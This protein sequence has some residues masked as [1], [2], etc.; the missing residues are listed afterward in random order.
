M[1]LTDDEIHAR[2]VRG[3]LINRLM[4]ILRGQFPKSEVFYID[5]SD[6]LYGSPSSGGGRGQIAIS[7]VE[8]STGEA[9]P[10]GRVTLRLENT[11]DVRF[12]A[13]FLEQSTRL[14][15][16]AMRNDK[17]IIED[18]R[19]HSI[20]I[21]PDF[22]IEPR[23][24][25]ELRGRSSQNRQTPAPDADEQ[26]MLATLK[27]GKE[28]RSR[29]PLPTGNTASQDFWNLEQPRGRVRTSDGLSFTTEDTISD[30]AW[31]LTDRALKK[32]KKSPD[33]EA[34][35]WTAALD[36]AHQA[37]EAHKHKPQRRQF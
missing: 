8:A 2:E 37:Y 30:Q 25:Q 3:S 33:T 26:A 16:A 36:E 1:H 18:H 14:L 11:D 29:S 6:S 35:I 31:Q 4:D 24:Q 19:N 21:T 34:D 9:N 22:I 23:L 20:H 32:D 17:N 10:H 5:G 7:T 12:D 15:R 13:V 28:S 27:R